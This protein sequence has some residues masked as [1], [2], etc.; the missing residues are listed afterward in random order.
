MVRGRRAGILAALAVVAAAAL[1][2]GCGGGSTSNAVSLD[3]VAA[4]ATK[5]QHAGA[6]RVKLALTL[7]SPQLRGKAVH[8]HATGAIDG[9]SGE[10]SFDLGPLIRG[11]GLPPAQMPSAT[12]SQLAHASVKEISLEE[13]GHYVIYVR[14]GFLSSQLPGGKQWLKL[15]LS[16][17]GKKAGLDIG[18]LLSGSQIQPGDLL[19]LLKAEGATVRKLGPA[20]VH[21]TPT[22]RYRVTVD[23]AKAAES[24]GLTSPMLSAIAAQMKTVSEDVWVGKDGLVRRI[25]LNYSL[26]K[27]SGS[28]R[29]AMKMDLYD[30]GAHVTIAAPPSGEVFDATLLAQQGLGGALH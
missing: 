22:T 2:A 1:A 25:G 28:P 26:P 29:L 16:K 14:L 12:M 23:L 21:G 30:Y 5:S 24:A 7:A 27:L 20:T 4:A 9:S 3:P 18:K 19:A 17:L 15:D 13:D 11:M 6:A 8:L 10:L